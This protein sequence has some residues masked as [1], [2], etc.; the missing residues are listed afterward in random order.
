MRPDFA[1][2][3]DRRRRARLHLIFG[4]LKLKT[5]E[6]SHY[7]VRR[8]GLNQTKER[9]DHD[10][11]EITQTRLRIRAGRAGRA[12]V[13]RRQRQGHRIPQRL[14]SALRAHRVSVERPKW[15]TS[16]VA[17]DHHRKGSRLRFGRPRPCLAV[18]GRSVREVA[19]MT[20]ASESLV[21]VR[22]HRAKNSLRK[23]LADWKEK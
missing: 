6:R 10:V 18:G 8:S 17:H 4:G 14:R 13:R 23:S 21:K 5:E 3:P 16:P 1:N 15:G 9:N 11:H 22:I 20:G 2:F 12:D 19:D 7:G